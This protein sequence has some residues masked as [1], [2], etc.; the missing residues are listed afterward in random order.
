MACENKTRVKKQVFYA[1]FLGLTFL[2]APG[3]C[4]YL[5]K[6]NQMRNIEL[7]MTVLHIDN[8][9]LYVTTQSL[10]CMCTLVYLP[11]AAIIYYTPRAHGIVM[12]IPATFRPHLLRPGHTVCL[13]RLQRG[14][15]LARLLVRRQD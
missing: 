5:H 6:V 13:V 7:N 4:I 11:A 3:A 10:H 8:G 15:R 14:P 1:I 9:I 12:H 2:R